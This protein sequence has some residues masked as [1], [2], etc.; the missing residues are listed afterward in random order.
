MS[1]IHVRIGSVMGS[2][3]PVYAPVPRASQTVA[4]SSSSAAA[5]V[6]AQA[7]DYIS[8]T[9]SAD[10]YVRIGAGTPTAVVGSGD[11]LL[12]GDTRDFGPCSEG[13]TVAAIDAGTL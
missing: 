7:G 11:L 1:S 3:A 9:A 5:T 10:V 8:V 2:T 13:Y 12:A 4:V 6:R